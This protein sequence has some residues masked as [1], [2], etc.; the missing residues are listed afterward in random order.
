MVVSSLLSLGIISS[1]SSPIYDCQAKA[2]RAST[3]AIGFMVEETLVNSK[4]STGQHILNISAK[5][6]HTARSG[7]PEL[8]LTPTTNE[9]GYQPFERSE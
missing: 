8:A 6:N 4:L 5:G 3:R 1:V 9:C 7:T 2:A